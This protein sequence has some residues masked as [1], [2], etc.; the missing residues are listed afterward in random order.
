LP[1]IDPRE[2][3]AVYFCPPPDHPLTRFAA[4]WLGR[5]LH[6]G[7]TLEPPT[8]PGFTPGR[9]A[10]LTASPRRYGFHATIKAPFHP[11]AGNTIEEI[12][13]ALVDLADGLDPVPVS[14]LHL[15]VLGGFLALVPAADAKPA[16]NRL[17]AACVRQ[18]DRFRAP[19]TAADRHRRHQAHRLSNRQSLFLD[20]WGYPFVFDEFRFHLT[21]TERLEDDEERA[22]LHDL[23]A[24][25]LTDI[26]AAPLRIDALC[27]C[28][29]PGPGQP[30]ILH[31]RVPL[32]AL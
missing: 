12:V 13:N 2:R 10:A 11:A 5:D 18:L 22:R 8:V 15:T 27:L 23:L 6:T 31:C 4:V 3:L 25:R 26:L 32:A 30:F 28:R 1:D 20:T 14:P 7:R 17:A 21:L 16:V 19:L 24:D 29:E 9:L